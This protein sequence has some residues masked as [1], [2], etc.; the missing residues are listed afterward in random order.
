MIGWRALRAQQSEIRWEGTGEEVIPTVVN[1]ADYTLIIG[2]SLLPS[3]VLY[4]FLS[5]QG[6]FLFLSVK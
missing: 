6:R 3:D 5:R 2:R 4:T 1:S